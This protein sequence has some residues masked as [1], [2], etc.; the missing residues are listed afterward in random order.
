MVRVG[1]LPSSPTRIAG[2]TLR[3]PS[4]ENLHRSTGNGWHMTSLQCLLVAMLDKFSWF[5]GWR[6]RHARRKRENEL[7]C[8]IWTLKSKIVYLGEEWMPLCRGG[9]RNKVIQTTKPKLSDSLVAV[10]L[11]LWW[12]REA[13]SKNTYCGGCWRNEYSLVKAL[14][15]SQ[16]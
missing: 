7:N 10:K 13:V 11:S 3:R 6:H 1:A 5:E 16:P 9:T 4:G 15:L 14:T 12:H 8:S 2:G